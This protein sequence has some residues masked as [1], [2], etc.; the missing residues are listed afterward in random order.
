MRKDI[1]YDEE[2][3]GFEHIEN[4]FVGLESFLPML[5]NTRL[6]TTRSYCSFDTIGL[7]RSCFKNEVL[8]SSPRDCILFAALSMEIPEMLPRLNR[9]TPTMCA[10]GKRLAATY[11]RK[12]SPQPASIIR[13]REPEA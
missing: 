8:E 11:I 7:V 2:P 9:S 6:E 13:R 12:P 5:W 3:S 1:S 4:R 10:F